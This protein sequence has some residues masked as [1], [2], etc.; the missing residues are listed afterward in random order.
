M[1]IAI[2]IFF[3]LFII[4][5]IYFFIHKYHESTEKGFS[6]QK[7]IGFFIFSGVMVLLS[8]TKLMYLFGIY[9]TTVFVYLDYQDRK[10]PIEINGSK[11]SFNTRMGMASIKISSFSPK[12]KFYS[13]DGV[14]KKTLGF[15]TYVVNSSQKYPIT[16]IEKKYKS[17]SGDFSNKDESDFVEV[18]KA[19]DFLKIDEE[20]DRCIVLPP[21]HKFPRVMDGKYKGKR[22][23]VTGRRRF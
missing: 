7:K 17:L 15:G 6:K 3:T 4:G 21:G 5:G 23:F 14:A 8:L 10:L 20:L 1:K 12:I 18:I 19:G 16:V 11:V 13:T 9:T 22:L 2:L